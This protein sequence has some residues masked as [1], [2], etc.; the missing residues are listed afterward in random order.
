MSRATKLAMHA[1][2]CFTIGESG[3]ASG[4]VVLA[5]AACTPEWKNFRWFGNIF[6]RGPYH[7]SERQEASHKQKDWRMAGFWR[8]FL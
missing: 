7:Y 1:C 4:L 5:S 6:A 2:Y 8:S 3:M